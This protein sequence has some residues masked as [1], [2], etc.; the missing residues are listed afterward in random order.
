M[1]IVR[2]GGRER[3]RRREREK[4]R[5]RGERETQSERDGE[6]KERAREREKERYFFPIITLFL[7]YVDVHFCSYLHKAEIFDTIN[8]TIKILNSDPYYTYNTVLRVHGFET[9]P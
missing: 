7:V 8:T 9:H 3:E 1:L 5:E 4:E 2:K 6:K